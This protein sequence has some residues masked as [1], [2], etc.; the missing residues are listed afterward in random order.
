MEKIREEID[1]QVFH[2][3]VQGYEA[4]RKAM[5]RTIQDMGLIN[6]KMAAMLMEY[7]D[8]GCIELDE[9]HPREEQMRICNQITENILKI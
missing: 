8:R 4:G 3:W 6:D 7:V 2:A 1:K 5:I 9:H